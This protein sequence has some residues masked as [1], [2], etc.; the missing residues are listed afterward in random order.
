MS[1]QCLEARDSLLFQGQPNIVHVDAYRREA[2]EHLGGVARLGVEGA[3]EGARVL[4]GGDGGLGQGVDGAG[5][6]ETVDVQRVGV[7][8]VLRRR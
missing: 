5:S 6:D 7:A 4:E 2:V 8:G 1:E 3:G